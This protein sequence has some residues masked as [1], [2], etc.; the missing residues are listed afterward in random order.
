MDRYHLAWLMVGKPKDIVR[1]RADDRRRGGGLRARGR[2]QKTAALR[3]SLD[4]VE[5]QGMPFR[6]ETGGV[7]AGQGMGEVPPRP[8]RR[9]RRRPDAVARSRTRRAPRPPPPEPDPRLQPLDPA[10]SRP[11]GA[12]RRRPQGVR[13]ARGPRRAPGAATGAA[14]AVTAPATRPARR[15]GRHPG[16]AGPGPDRPRLPPARAAARPARPGHRRRLLRP[17][18]SQGAGRPGAARGPWRAS[19]RTPPPSATGCRRRPRSPPAATGSTSSSSRS[20]R[21]PGPT[22]ARPIPYLDLVTR[23]FAFTPRRRPDERFEAAAAHLDALL[24]G[25]GPLAPRLAA[26]D[27]RWTIPPDRVQGVVEA[28]VPRYRERAAALYGLP[29]DEDLRVTPR[30]RPAVDAATTG[31]TAATARGSTSTSTCRCGCPALVGVTAH[32]TYPGPPPGAR[33]QGAG[34][35]RGARPARGERAPDQHAR[36]PD[37]RGPGERRARRIAVPPAERPALLVE[38]ACSRAS[39]SRRDAGALREA[40]ARQAPSP[41]RAGSSTSRG[42]TPR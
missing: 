27:A 23:C 16:R 15:R 32:E 28:L 36:V 35:R 29:A 26:E 20:R 1:G 24:P 21:S 14:P 5:R 17:G 12:T 7:G 38:L 2:V 42:S 11:P 6:G 19:P 41:R 18:G 39:R 4:A 13:R 34:A 22:A 8:R 30:P 10:R 3:M 33:A 40:A 31:T 9:A 37:L 25:R